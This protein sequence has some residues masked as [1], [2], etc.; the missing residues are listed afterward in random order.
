MP[1]LLHN[2]TRYSF[3]NTKKTPFN[4]RL[5]TYKLTHTLTV[6]QWRESGWIRNFGFNRHLNI[7]RGTIKP[8]DSP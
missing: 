8:M 3:Q 7:E 5:G 2:N 1:I 4:V 6:A